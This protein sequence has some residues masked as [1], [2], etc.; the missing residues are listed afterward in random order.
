[1]NAQKRMEE[2]ISKQ[3]YDRGHDRDHP[4]TDNLHGNFCGSH[5]GPVWKEH[6]PVAVVKQGLYL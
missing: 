4:D 5:V 1:M 3:I 6:L 2:A